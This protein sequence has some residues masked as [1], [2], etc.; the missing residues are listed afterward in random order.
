MARLTHVPLTKA[1][2]LR[3]P[4]PRASVK[5]FGINIKEGIHERKFILVYR[6]LNT[7]DCVEF[8]K[9]KRLNLACTSSTSG[10]AVSGDG[11]LSFIDLNFFFSLSPS[12]SP[13]HPCVHT[14]VGAC[15][16]MY[17]KIRDG[18]QASFFFYYPCWVLGPNSGLVSLGDKHFY[19]L[20]HLTS[21]SEPWGIQIM[22]M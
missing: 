7:T 20:S 2:S 17:L 10:G 11:L 21:T 14:S 18:L 5:Y 6:L 9:E 4:L 15:Y 12:L 22:K 3:A 8:I 13:P 19:L 1:F 16:S